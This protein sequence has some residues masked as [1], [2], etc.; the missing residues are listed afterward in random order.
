M[1]KPRF[2]YLVVCFWEWLALSESLFHHLKEDVGLVDPNGPPISKT[3][4]T[5]SLTQLLPFQIPLYFLIVMLSFLSISELQ[6]VLRF[7]TL[8]LYSH[9]KYLLWES[10]DIGLVPLFFTSLSPAHSLVNPSYWL[11]ALVRGWVNCSNWYFINH[12][13]GFSFPI[14]LSVNFVSVPS[15][16]NSRHF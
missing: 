11:K 2:C 12:S 10:K 15:F 13:V 4:L 8:L 16:F 6:G 5:I 7:Q 14:T 3:P 9:V 1:N